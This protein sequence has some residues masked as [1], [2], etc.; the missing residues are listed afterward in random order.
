MRTTATT[1]ELVEIVDV[2]FDNNMSC[3]RSLKHERETQHNTSG[4]EG[5]HLVTDGSPLLALR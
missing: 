1:L 2:S 4:P 3:R 5:F